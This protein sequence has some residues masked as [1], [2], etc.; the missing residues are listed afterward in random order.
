MQSNSVNEFINNVKL[1]FN[2]LKKPW[3]H[4]VKFYKEEIE[5]KRSEIIA[6]IDKINEYNKN[7]FQRRL[8]N[9]YQKW[10]TNGKNNCFC[11][12]KFAFNRNLPENF[13]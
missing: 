7:S 10:I 12:L 4:P 6:I 13:V 5:Q 3:R 8:G 2:Y 11:D 1:I 9:Y